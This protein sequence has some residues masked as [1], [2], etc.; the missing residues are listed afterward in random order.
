MLYKI[1]SALAMK[2]PLEKFIH[3]ELYCRGFDKEYNWVGFEKARK[4]WLT[5]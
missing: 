4:V 2:I 1:Q 5:E 3:F